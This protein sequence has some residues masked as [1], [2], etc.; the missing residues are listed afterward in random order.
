MK[1][2]GIPERLS[3]AAAA[4]KNARRVLITGHVSPDGDCVGS[5]LAVAHALRGMG[6]EALIFSAEP[7]PYNYEF[8]PGSGMIS[9]EAHGRFDA[10]LILDLSDRERVGKGFPWRSAGRIVNIDHHSTGRGL[11]SLQVRDADASATGELVYALLKKMGA[12]ITPDVATCLYCAILTDTGSF[13]YS[14]STPGAYEIAGKLVA[15]GARPWEIASRIYEAEPAERMAL[16]GRSLSTLEMHCGGRLAMLVV[17]SEMYAATGATKDM[18]DQFVN[19]AR[20]IRGVQ[21]AGFLRQLPDGSFK[22][23][24]RSRGDVDVSKIGLRFGG[25]GHRNAAG[26]NLPGPL[27]AAK[28]TLVQ[29]VGEVLGCTVSSASTSRRE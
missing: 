24:L 14:N 12:G 22:G 2:T 17:T 3:R 26:L 28:A 20:S 18:T 10:A 21:V 11:G 15:K 8:L 13:R 25:G 7:V 27:D 29:A 23:S 6:R 16:L 19:Y 5:C 9:A 4:L 1:R